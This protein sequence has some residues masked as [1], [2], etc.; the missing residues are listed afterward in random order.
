MAI[1]VGQK[2][3]N[4]S[5]A[6]TV[7][8]TTNGFT[9]H[10]FS[11]VGV[12]TFTAQGSGLV[13]V[14]VVGGGGGGSFTNSSWDGGGGGG[15]VLYAKNVPLIGGVSYTAT[16]GGAGIAVTNTPAGFG[17]TSILAHNNGSITA[18]GGGYG[19]CRNPA[20]VAANNPVGSAGG[21]ARSAG[22]GGIGAGIIGYGFPGGP[23][24]VPSSFGGGGGG[25]GGAGGIAVGGTG[26]PYSITGVST[27]YG[28]GGCPSAMNANSFPTMFGLGQSPLGG[29]PVGGNRGCIIIRYQY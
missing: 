1:I 28:G 24:T 8:I 23:G 20:Y 26:L 21:D 13:E 16:V 2:I 17:G 14:L 5:N 18:P 12:T 6:T 11:T 4:I 19:G 7:G 3:V 10:T 25:A 27:F 22:I 29:A 9:V 15:S